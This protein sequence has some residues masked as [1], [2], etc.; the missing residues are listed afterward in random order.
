MIAGGLLNSGA[1]VA[2][3][4][5]GEDTLSK[6]EEA[7]KKQVWKLQKPTDKSNNVGNENEMEN[8]GHQLLLG[9]FGTT[10]D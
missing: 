7:E 1:L 10:A 3:D 8:V 5:I 9:R 6:F 4:E 2:T